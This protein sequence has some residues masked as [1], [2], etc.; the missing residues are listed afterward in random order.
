MNHFDLHQIRSI[1]DV[2]GDTFT[3][4][5]V[6][7]KSLAKVFAIYVLGPL[8]LGSVLFGTAFGGIFGD[9]LGGAGA[10]SPPAEP[11]FSSMVGAGASIIAGS[12]FLLAS[13]FLLY[14][15]I[16]QHLNHAKKATI[17]QDISEF[18][19]GIL[20]K[21]VRLLGVFLLLMVI[22]LALTS[23]V[24]LLVAQ[25][26]F[27]LLLI[28]I[29]LLLYIFIR[30][31]LTPIIIFTEDSDIITS[32]SRSWNLT[33]GYFWQTFGVYLLITIVFGILSQM[34]SVPFG[35]IIGFMGI[36]FDADSGN[37][38]GILM[39]LMYTI[40]FIFQTIFMAAQVIAFGIQYFN[41]KERK[42]G[43]SLDSEIAGL[44]ASL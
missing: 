41:L 4:I 40:T 43:T 22:Y 20:S 27:W 17:P 24:F 35:V 12:I 37:V 31:L 1:G 2:L 34:L 21:G 14:A 6:Y 32:I 16:C 25:I 5:R 3:Y 13:I 10:G 15:V 44:E 23:I 26:S 33:Q 39:G 30:L 29:P 18:S 8:M 38:M 19:E 28:G 11:D 42:M 7:Y 36:A 9:V